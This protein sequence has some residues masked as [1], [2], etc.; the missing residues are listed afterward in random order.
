MNVKQYLLA[1]IHDHAYRERAWVFSVLA[2]SGDD[3][4]WEGPGEGR[5]LVPYQALRSANRDEWL[6]WNPELNAFDR[7]E[8]LD[9]N[10]PVFRG[11]DE[12][13]LDPTDWAIIKEPTVTTFGRILANLYYF[14]DVLGDR[15]PFFNQEFS[16]GMLEK[17]FEKYFR[18]P[19]HPQFNDPDTITYDEFNR[20]VNNG[21]SMAPLSRVCVATA[22]PETM[23]PPKWLV[24]MRDKLFEEH[25]HELS[26]PL[27]MGRIQDELLKAYKAFLATTPSK[28]SFI[29]AKTVNDAFNKMFVSG[30]I[31]TNFGVSTVVTRSLYEGWD[32]KQ[33][34]A[35]ANSAIEASFG[36]GASTA[37]GGEKVKMLIRATQNILIRKDD[38]GSRLGI[39]WIVDDNVIKLQENAYGFIDGKTTLLTKENLTKLKGKPILIRSPNFCKLTHG[40]SCQYCAGAHN[41]TNERGASSGTSAV[42]SKIMLLSMKAMHKGSKID[43]VKLDLDEIFF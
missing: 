25:K 26:D 13:A 3:H 24:E 5:G 4:E 22:C 17:Y 39:P 14:Y 41:S 18:N 9:P 16:R 40:D 30:G 2:I 37:D 42:G 27:V 29:K 35:L 11:S 19:D 7:I 32:L 21:F 12:I 8:D 28:N 33:L 10:F 36:R 43:L 6:F 20:C 23:Y 15:A 34:P 31:S 38:C 1:A